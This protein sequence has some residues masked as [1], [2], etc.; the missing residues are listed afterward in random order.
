[1]R[2][3]QHGFNGDAGNGDLPH[4]YHHQCVAYT[5][6]HDHDTTVGWFKRA[7]K[8]EREYCKK[9]LHSKGRELHWD[10]IRALLASVAG[11]AI[12]PMQDILGLDSEARMNL[13]A[14]TGKNWQW[15]LKEG[16][17]TDDVIARLQEMTETY[18]RSKQ[19]RPDS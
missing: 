1:M 17:L 16:E 15:R 6:T 9:Y 18:G 8:H 3:L 4:H 7:S 2:I 11:T 19:P 13:P 14:T 10:M 12:I 5:G